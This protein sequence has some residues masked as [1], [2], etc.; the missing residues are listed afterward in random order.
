MDDS[1]LAL[2][3]GAMAPFL[4]PLGFG[5]WQAGAALLTGFM[6]KEVVVSTMNIMYYAP[7]VDTLQALMTTHYTALSAYSFMAFILLYIPCMATVATIKKETGSMK[8]TIIS[9]A[10][11]LVLAYALS[12]LIYQ[13]GSLLGY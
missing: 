13:I 1:F 7:D 2:I 6:A 8:W 3:G 4:G 10:Y 9:I 11:A 12:F 5:T